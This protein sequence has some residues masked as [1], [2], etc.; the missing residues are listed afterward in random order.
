MG[1]SQI[2]QSGFVGKEEKIYQA[3]EKQ[4][5]SFFKKG[6]TVALMSG[7]TYGIYT[8]LLTGGMSKGI[9]SD[10][11]GPNTAGL[12]TFVILYLLGAIATGINDTSS[13]L[14]SLGNAGFKGKIPDLFRVVKTKPGKIMIAAALIGGP[15]AGTAYIIGIQMA[16]PIAVPISALCPAIAAIIGK[17]FYGQELNKRMALGISICV[18]SSFIIGFDG[19][20]NTADPLV[21][22]GLSLSIIA[23]L[24][25]GIEG[26]VAGYASTMVDSDIGICIRQTTSGL[27]NLL[28][29]VPLLGVISGEMGISYSLLFQALTSAPAMIWFVF[30]GLGA[31][32]GFSLWYKG[33]SM[34]G[35][36]LGA[37]C[38][39]TF[40]FFGPF[41][42]FLFLGVLDGQEGWSLGINVWLAVILMVFGILVISTNPLELL[43]KK[44]EN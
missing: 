40:S 42:C 6:V 11:Y 15:L 7:V 9:W 38:N 12:S 30:S 1:S 29:I 26:C 13:A 27:T 23:A 14:W 22:L 2:L 31:F 39:G 19:L 32:F 21:L 10:W 44:E 5:Q 18:A 25:W 24:G 33:N 8:A 4:K 41:F 20:S 34:C 16:G 36:G 28:I 17:V 43:R 37:A 35:T 3:R